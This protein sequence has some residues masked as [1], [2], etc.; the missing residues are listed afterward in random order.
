[1]AEPTRSATAR[2][3]GMGAVKYADLV[4]DLGRD[5]VFSLDR[6]VAMD[7]N[8]GPYLQYAHARLASLLA[9]TPAAPTQ[10]LR[11]EHPAEQRLALLLTGF[12]GTVEQVTATLEPHRLCTHLYRVATALSVFYEQCRSS[13]QT[14]T[15]GT[16]SSRSASSL[17]GSSRPAWTC[18]ASP[19]PTGCNSRTPRIRR[20][21][22]AGLHWRSEMLL[23][24]KVR[25]APPADCSALVV[26]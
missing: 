11:L 1:M 14:E 21:C 15:S 16:A 20:R 26:V 8:T 10:V 19:R 6:M 17:D 2:A 7:G 4:N 18:S 24:P 3:I 23:M 12:A 22:S 9:K 5:Y 25:A 13:R